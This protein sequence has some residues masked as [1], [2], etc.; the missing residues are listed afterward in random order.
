MHEKH[1]TKFTLTH[2]FKKKKK[3]SGNYDYKCYLELDKEHL[4]KTYT[5]IIFNGKKVCSS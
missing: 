2:D 1:F 5:N 3:L 4:Q